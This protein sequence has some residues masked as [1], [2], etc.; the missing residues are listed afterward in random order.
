MT[1]KTD[2][3]IDRLAADLAPVRPLRPPGLRAAWWVLVAVVYFAILTLARPG[4]GFELD[5]N[6]VGFLVIQAIG[7]VAGVLAA[8]AAFASVVPGYPNRMTVWALISAFG[9]LAIMAVSAFGANESAAIWSAQHEWV[10]VAVIVIGGAPLIAAL[11]IM[12]RRGAPLSPIR[13]GLLTAV[14]VGLLANFAAC[15]SRPHAADVVTLVW[16]GSAVLGLIVVCVASARFVLRWNA[17]ES[18]HPSEVRQ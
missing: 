10:C 13:T 1:M 8:I 17:G 3:V 2:D 9:W 5:G 4:F 7:F 6:V 12:L 11:S 14:A 16:H 15:F 18:S